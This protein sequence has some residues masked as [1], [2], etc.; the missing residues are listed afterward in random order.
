[1]RIW[2]NVMSIKNIDNPINS[3]TLTVLLLILVSLWMP[4]VFSYHK[5]KSQQK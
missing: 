4:R 5:T 2:S 1:M 3:F